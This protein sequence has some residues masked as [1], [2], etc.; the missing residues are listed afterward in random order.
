[1]SECIATGLGFLACPVILKAFTAT[2]GKFVRFLAVSFILFTVTSAII[3][4]P[5]ST[6]LTIACVA[7]SVFLMGICVG[8]GYVIMSEYLD[9]NLAIGITIAVG[10][11]AAIIL[12]YLLNLWASFS[13][14]LLFSVTAFFYVVMFEIKSFLVIKDIMDRGHMN[15]GAPANSVDGETK[16]SV[17]MELARI[18]LLSVCFLLLSSYLDE[19]LTI[20]FDVEAYFSGPRLVFVVGSLSMGFIWDKSKGGLAPGV[21]IL[22]SLMALLIPILLVDERFYIVDMC[23]FYFYIGICMTYLILIS[24]RFA[25]QSG[26]LYSAVI[27]KAVDNLLTAALVLVGIGRISMI[28]ITIMDV[29]VLSIALF[30]M[31][32]GGDFSSVNN[33]SRFVLGKDIDMTKEYLP[34]SDSPEDR[35]AEFAEKYKLTDRESEALRLLLTSDMKGDDMAKELFVSRRGFVSFT[36]SIYHKT[37]TTSRIGLMQKYMAEEFGGE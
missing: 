6:K 22:A 18:V 19:Q 17:V 14:M 10:Y 1:M 11:S 7:F 28:P 4:M 34:V 27:F 21:M 37:N 26:S 32:I 5:I 3:L 15:P 36:T 33:W 29:I 13:A 12:H 16:I 31:W 2:R 30:L 24:L 23:L 25:K 35:M 9:T 20:L 8:I